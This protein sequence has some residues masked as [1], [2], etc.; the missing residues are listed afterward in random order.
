MDKSISWSTNNLEGRYVAW[1][2]S[3]HRGGVG[4]GGY[5]RRPTPRPREPQG[6]EIEWMGAEGA[7]GGSV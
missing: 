6:V 1:V 4:W 3:A 2:T 7:G 5:H